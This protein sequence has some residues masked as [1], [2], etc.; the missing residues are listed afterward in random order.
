MEK[1]EKQ[2]II[3]G[4]ILNSIGLFI[5]LI[6]VLL[7]IVPNYTAISDNYKTGNDLFSSINRIKSN[8]LNIDEVQAGF[9]QAK[10]KGVENL[11][12]DKEKVDELIKKPDNYSKDY[13]SWINEEL[14]KSD[15]ITKEIKKGNQIIGNIIP[16]F[17]DF[18][19]KIKVTKDNGKILNKINMDSFISYIENGVLKK[20]SLTSYTSIGI[21]N[22]DYSINKDLGL[23]IGTF[24][25]NL[26]FEGTI[27]SI[28]TMIR[29]FQN[30]GKIRIE[31][32]KLVGITKNTDEEFSSLNNLLITIDSLQLS[33]FSNNNLPV[34]GNIALQFYIKGAGLQDYILIKD[35]LIKET[36]DLLSLIKEGAKTCD[37]G[38]NTICKNN[39]G[40]EAVY[41]I[42]SLLSQINSIKE[43][44]TE[45]Q[46]NMKIDNIDKE[47]SNLFQIYSS[48]KR[49]RGI[50]DK[51]M[52]IINKK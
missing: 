10:I 2:K 39:D 29:D 16:T 24:K 47:F 37:K 35:A 28:K 26:D 23:N 32:G 33:D 5:C 14:L 45:L 51:N 49:I 31:N 20:Y 52:A 12:K 4:I 50:Y 3:R 7:Y 38:N 40:N 42:K 25:I 1:K 27:S 21:D 34:K 8:G 48:L 13:I 44:T 22:I 6:I 17:N 41:N 11:F 36:N 19:D 46:K 9:N 43:K 15:T 30:S 18:G